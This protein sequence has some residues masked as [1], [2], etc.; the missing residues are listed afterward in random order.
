M[1]TLIQELAKETGIYDCLC[2]PYDRHNTGDAHGSVMDDLER[3]AELIVQ[4]CEKVSLKCSHRGDDMGAIIAR[5]I[6]EHFGIET[7]D[8]TL[9]NRSTY[10]GN[11]P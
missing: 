9:R 3:F 7:V 8:S 4:E 10:F 5:N 1:N 11:N 2:D 6:R